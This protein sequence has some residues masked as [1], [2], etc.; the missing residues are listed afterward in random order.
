MKIEG[1]GCLR[2]MD[3]LADATIDGTRSAVVTTLAWKFEI[4]ETDGG[5]LTIRCK[6]RLAGGSVHALV[7]VPQ[8][9]RTI[10]VEGR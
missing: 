3:P 2:T 7:V 5:N 8:G 6:E 10:D 9:S 1:G 4:T